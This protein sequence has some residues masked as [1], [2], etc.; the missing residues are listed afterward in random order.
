MLTLGQVSDIID[1]KRVLGPPDEIQEVKNAIAAYK[2]IEKVNPFE[3]KDLLRIH[4]V[5]MAGLVDE[6]G[7]L[8]TVNE[9][10][11]SSDGKVVNIAPPPD[12]VPEHMN[13]LFAWLKTSRVHALIKSSV[14]HYKFEFIHP[15]RDGN[16]RTGRLW[17][18]AILMNWKPVFA[19]IPVESIIRERQAEYYNAIA[20]STSSGN[21]DAFILYIL[22]VILDAVKAIGRDAQ[23]HI[24]HIS[25]RVR[26][27]LAVLE[28][29]PMEATE[30]MRKL[31]LKSRDALRRNYLAPAIEAGL[32]MMTDP[33]KPTNKN[34]R[35]FKKA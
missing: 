18:T 31:G 17:Q 1:G 21:S 8:R 9:G 33:G 25:T 6:A 29:Y 27:L 2:E 3:L 16:G 26:D 14:F 23:A 15:F 5:I 20:Q 4:G 34:Q 30:I 22:K 35:Y 13:N 10:I 28:V 32:V 12:M 7:K 11:Y 19:W 24:N